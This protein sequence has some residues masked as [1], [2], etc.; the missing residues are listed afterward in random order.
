MAL[1]SI[2]YL[3][4]CAGAHKIINKFLLMQHGCSTYLFISGPCRG[5]IIIIIQF[6]IIIIIIII[7]VVMM[8]MMMIITTTTETNLKI[9][10]SS[11][12]L[13]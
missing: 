4:S 13:R 8:I 12:H 9:L 6:L 1:F 2:I 7:V 10:K 3:M 11:L 5:S